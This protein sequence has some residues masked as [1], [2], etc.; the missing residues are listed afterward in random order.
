VGYCAWGLAPSTIDSVCA[1]HS[2]ALLRWYCLLCMET[3]QGSF[4]G[5]ARNLYQVAFVAGIYWC[6]LIVG[7]WWLVHWG[8][9]RSSSTQGL[10]GSLRM[11]LSL[12]GTRVS[13]KRECVTHL[14][15]CQRL[16]VHHSLGPKSNPR[17]PQW[18]SLDDTQQLAR[19]TD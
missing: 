11:H 15:V 8:A 16:Q 1:C 19:F 10:T 14:R 4:A 6:S 17:Q 3:H 7:T 9:G 2:C 13:L 5:W 12:S 18:L